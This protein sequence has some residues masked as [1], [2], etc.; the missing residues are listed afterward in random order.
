M[1]DTITPTSVI[2][3]EEF[4]PWRNVVQLGP[5]LAAETRQI[6]SYANHHSGFK[7]GAV[8]VGYSDSGS[9]G[10]FKGAN[11]NLRLGPNPT[12]VCAEQVALQKLVHHRFEHLIAMF[13]SGPVQPDTQS[14]R[15]MPTLHSCG[16]CRTVMAARPEVRDDTLVVSVHPD[17]DSYE[18]YTFGEL[19]IAHD[20]GTETELVSRHFHDSDFATWE[21]GKAVYDLQVGGLLEPVQASASELARLAVTGQLESSHAV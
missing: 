19:V 3:A 9:F 21:A 8:A 2:R 10:L 13:V 16:E 15:D 12:K 14:G 1:R 6:R 7:V 4:D 20:T 18:I 5:Y 17:E 11:Q